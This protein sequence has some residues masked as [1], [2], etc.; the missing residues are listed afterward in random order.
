MVCVVFMSV[1]H[2]NV[3]GEE[4]GNTTDLV[5]IVGGHNSCRK[6]FFIQDDSCCFVRYYANTCLAGKVRLSSDMSQDE[7]LREISWYLEES[8]PFSIDTRM[9]IYQVRSIIIGN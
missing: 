4:H 7:I 3:E 8:V 5:C 2:V 9:S 6:H 1:K